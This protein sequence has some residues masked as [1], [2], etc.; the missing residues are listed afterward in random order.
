MWQ[1]VVASTLLAAVVCYAHYELPHFTRG[2]TKRV[3]AHAILIV[4]GAAFGAVCSWMP[5]VPMPRWLAFVAGFGAVHT[6]GAAIL[7]IKRMRG[8]RMS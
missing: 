1:G 8:S 5:D 7:L 2:A 6:P 3:T 4:A